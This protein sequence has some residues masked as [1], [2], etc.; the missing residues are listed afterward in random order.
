MST[1][2]YP[3]LV[4]GGDGTGV[5]AVLVGDFECTAA[6]G[7]TE[8][9]AL[10]QLKELLVWRQH[11][12]PWNVDSDLLEAQLVHVEVEVRPQYR[13]RQRLV[14]CRE[15]VRMRVPCVTGRQEA[16]LRLCVVPHLGLQFN[17]QESADLKG[18][19]VHYVKEDLHGLSPSALARRWPPAPCR[20]TEVIVKSAPGSRRDRTE[21]G[22]DPEVLS[23]VAESMLASAG[24]RRASGT[25][26]GRDTLVE[27]VSTLLGGPR[28]NLLLVGEPGV[29]K[30]TI[31]TAAAR[32]LARLGQTGTREAEHD[33][34]ESTG[35]TRFWR[36]SAGR[37]VAGMRYLGEWEERC[38]AV[39]AELREV[40]GVL[41]AENLLELLST[42]GEGP[43]ASV[44]AFLLPYLERGELQLATEASPAEVEACR[45]WLPGLLDV[46]RIVP[47]PAFEDAEAVRV[48]ERVAAGPALTAKTDLEPGAVA[49]V[50]RLFRR[51][52][53]YL[54]MP[55]PAAEFTRSLAARGGVAGEG[56]RRRI[57]EPEVVA[58]FVRRTGL[59]EA[60]LRDEIPMD[61]EAV[62]AHFAGRIV[63][64]S[65]A[66][67][68]AARMV[69]MMKAGM[70]D[71][72]RPQAVS[73]FCGPTGVG[74]TALAR[75]LVEFCFGAGA[76]KDRLVRLDMSEYAGG[77][78][79]FRL[80][81]DGRGGP[82]PWIARVRRQP[83]CVVLLDEIEKAAPE[84]FDVLLSVLDEGRL[85]D[86]FGRVTWFRG[87]LILLTSNLGAGA[88]GVSGF[89]SGP[90]TDYRSEV[91]RH[92]RPEFFNR[93][94][95]VVTFRALA[96]A[97][98]EAIVAKELRDLA[99]REGLSEAGLRL[100]WTDA[101]VRWIAREGYD[102]RFGARPL[103][104]ALERRVVTPL[105]RWRLAHPTVRDRTLELDLGPDDAV[106]IRPVG[107]RDVRA[108]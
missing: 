73:L 15:T 48:L 44:G 97:D 13:L 71:P 66:T 3:V 11:A 105:A 63:G 46:F 65:E 98:V 32:R 34:E 54:A 12:E 107:T 38:E 102:A 62:R 106:L 37:M 26:Y 52:Q 23:A 95:S 104:R 2:R 94:D 85:T 87:A 33:E 69:M 29:G 40:G 25:A 70:T 21:A 96:S 88:T 78:A 19:V 74:K 79:T 14:P 43:G 27:T 50:H 108:A 75:E 60:L 22:R 83:F 20:L 31:L 35:R 55:G 86:R 1:V 67:E 17:Y 82:A 8:E 49:L 103:Q 57:G 4:W 59:P 51:Y 76:E 90:V 81:D 91:A 68:A 16:G 64:Q 61:F 42:G 93:L 41:F 47:I 36:T 77:A 9:E 28:A 92:F 18:L 100:R 101:L 24:R 53:P 58:A 99:G 80:L 89:S 10:R 30:S 45:R 84:V 72:A 56:D 7:A 39:I 6:T 5:T